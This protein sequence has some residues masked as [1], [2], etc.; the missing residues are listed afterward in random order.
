M[1][2][3]T[4]AG[5]AATYKR[6]S[7][8]RILSR[9]LTTWLKDKLNPLAGLSCITDACV[10]ESASLIVDV[11]LTLNSWGSLARLTEHE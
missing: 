4:E 5:V 7:V 1:Y 10:L 6:L 3:C 8:E 9:V 11:D 2:F